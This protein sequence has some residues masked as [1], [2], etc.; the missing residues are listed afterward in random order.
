M[1]GKLEFL[2]HIELEFQK[3]YD[4]FEQGYIQLLELDNQERI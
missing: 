1:K 4:N 2:E 3:V